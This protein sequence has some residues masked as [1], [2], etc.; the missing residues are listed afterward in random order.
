MKKLIEKIERNKLISVIIFV[1][2][3]LF[4]Y[5]NYKTFKKEIISNKELLVNYKKN[6][7]ELE[8]YRTPKIAVLLYEKNNLNM[9]ISPSKNYLP[10]LYKKYGRPKTFLIFNPVF[11]QE[12]IAAIAK[13]N[14]LIPKAIELNSENLD[15]FFVVYNKDNHLANI[16]N[17]IERHKNELNDIIERSVKQKKRAYRVSKKNYPHALFDKGNSFVYDYNGVEVG[18]LNAKIG[19]AQDIANNIYEAKKQNANLDNMVVALLTEI[20]QVKYTS[21]EDFFNKFKEGVHGV[22]L[23]DG[24]RQAVMMPYMW[25]KY[26][27]KKEFIDALKIKAKILPNYKSNK[28]DFYIFE[29]VEIKLNKPDS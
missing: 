11:E 29:V 9:I 16:S 15:N 26:P 25:A 28:I 24:N 21:E 5:A 27:T 4:F 3:A 17:F 19:I 6:A 20:K 2:I 7:D 23:R 1:I 13:A 14:N 18:S 22:V 12:Q 8:N 10:Y